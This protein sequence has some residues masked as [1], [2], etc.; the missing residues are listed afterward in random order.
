[1]NFFLSDFWATPW[2]NNLQFNQLERLQ[3]VA[4]DLYITL[5]YTIFLLFV[6]KACVL[7][8]GPKRTPSKHVRGGGPSYVVLRRRGASEQVNTK[9]KQGSP[10]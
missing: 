1:M 3:R 7:Q 2:S 8:Y 6:L 10:P 4:G 9:Q 5:D